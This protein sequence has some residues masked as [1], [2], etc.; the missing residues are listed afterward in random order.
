MGPEAALHT[1]KCSGLGPPCREAGRGL[2]GSEAVT[3][4]MGTYWRL[5]RPLVW[6]LQGWPQAFLKLALQGRPHWCPS[7]VTKG[8]AQA[9]EVGKRAQDTQLLCPAARLPVQ[10][11]FPPVCLSCRGTWDQALSKWQLAS[12]RPRAN[13]DEPAGC[14]QQPPT[15]RPGA[16]RPRGKGHQALGLQTPPCL[17]CSRSTASS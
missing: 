4:T 8:K 7:H 14:W 10:G 13:G 16:R 1:G 11:H 3:E 5:P 17:T 6:A 12:R 9:R 2:T 15:L